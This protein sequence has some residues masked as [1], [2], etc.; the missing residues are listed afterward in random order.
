MQN[1]LKYTIARLAEQIS[2]KFS[3]MRITISIMYFI[4]AFASRAVSIAA[5][6]LRVCKFG[7]NTFSIARP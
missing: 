6:K 1:V 5:T 3:Y 2:F 7:M 4:H